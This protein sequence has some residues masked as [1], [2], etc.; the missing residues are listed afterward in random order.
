MAVKEAGIII[1]DGKQVASTKQC[2]HCGCHFVMIKGSGK[3]RGFCTKCAEVTC[4]KI[5][6]CTCVP[7]EKKLELVEAGKLVFI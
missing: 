4:G 6:C 1:V 5:G 7:F 2:C 3:L